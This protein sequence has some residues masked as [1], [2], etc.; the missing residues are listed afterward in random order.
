MR[1]SLPHKEQTHQWCPTVAVLLVALCYVDEY[2]VQEGKVRLCGL[3]PIPLGLDTTAIDIIR[4]ATGVT[5]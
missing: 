1:R 3:R 5:R 4:V 2:M